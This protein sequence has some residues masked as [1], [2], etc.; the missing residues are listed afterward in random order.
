M[1][2]ERVHPAKGLQGCCGDMEHLEM[3]LQS[4]LPVSE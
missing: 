3:L 2:P 4:W 1:I